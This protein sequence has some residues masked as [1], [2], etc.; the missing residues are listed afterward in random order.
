MHLLQ[1]CLFSPVPF[2]RKYELT[3]FGS[4]DRW[5]WILVLV[6]THEVDSFGHLFLHKGLY[7]HS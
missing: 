1:S 6:W 7:V 2:C 4:V 3:C 5:T